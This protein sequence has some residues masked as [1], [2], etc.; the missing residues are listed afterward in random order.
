[1]K[2]VVKSRELK[3]QGKNL[4]TGN[5]VEAMSER[6]HKHI[7]LLR[8]IGKVEE[9]PDPK[10]V[11]KVVSTRAAEPVAEPVEAPTPEPEAPV[12]VEPLTTDDL[13]SDG[14]RYRNRRLK[15]ED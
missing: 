3:W 13:P 6:D 8:K 10:P 12:V 1:M 2:Y 7:E 15:S 4:V 14:L 5:P 9:A 11:R